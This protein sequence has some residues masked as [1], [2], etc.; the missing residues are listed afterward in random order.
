MQEE[1]YYIYNLDSFIHLLQD[2]KLTD[3][4]PSSVMTTRIGH[5]VASNDHQLRNARVGDPDLQPGD[6]QE[7]ILGHLDPGFIILNAES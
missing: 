3:G 5:R 1:F 4:K 2:P 7:R 6:I